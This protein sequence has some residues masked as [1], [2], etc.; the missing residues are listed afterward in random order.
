MNAQTILEYCTGKRGAYLNAPFGVEPICARIGRRIFAEVF[1]SRPW[2]TLKC[3]P[4][5]GAAMRA[6][7][8]RQIRRGYH[9][10]PPQHPY[11][12]TVTLDGTVPDDRLTEM[13]DHSYERAMRTLTKSE[14]EAV[15]AR[16]PQVTAE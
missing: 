6:A 9:C 14:R 5:Y 1:L 12:N 15:L 16:R 2:V 11:S 4:V 3:E 13:I 7:Y 10:P 8:P